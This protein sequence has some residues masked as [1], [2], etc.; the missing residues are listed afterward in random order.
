MLVVKTK[1]R[2]RIPSN[3]GIPKFASAPMNASNPPAKIAGSTSGRVILL[4]I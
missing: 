2:A 4:M 1:N 3:A